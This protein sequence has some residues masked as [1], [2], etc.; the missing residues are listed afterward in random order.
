MLSLTAQENT[1]AQTNS[2]RPSPLF[3]VEGSEFIELAGESQSAKKTSNKSSKK[4]TKQSTK[5]KKS[6]T[7][8]LD[9]QK[10]D[11]QVLNNVNDASASTFAV[12]EATKLQSMLLDT[13]YV[14][15]E[16]RRRQT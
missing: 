8:N 10:L 3:T 9:E 1:Q 7:A 12:K 16:R 2:K 15:A 13:A 11:E 14:P 4:S 6:K 5:A